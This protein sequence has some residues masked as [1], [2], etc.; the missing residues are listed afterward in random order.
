M[1]SELSRTANVYVSAARDRRM[2]HGRTGGCTSG[3]Y[4]FSS[5]DEID[6]QTAAALR[7]AS[8]SG[9]LSPTFRAESLATLGT[10]GVA[11]KLA[12]RIAQPL[13]AARVVAAG[14]NL[15]L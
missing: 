15:E 2:L 6:G 13:G 5:P 3:E 10:T 11:G 14:R 9:W 7:N 4:C 8:V 12:L 1:A